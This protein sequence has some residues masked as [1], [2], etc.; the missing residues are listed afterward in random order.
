MTGTDVKQLQIFL[1]THNFTVSNTGPG[2]RGQET[3]YF[4]P[5][6]YRALVKFQEYYAKDILIPVGL[7]RGTGYFG[8][9]TMKKVNQ[10]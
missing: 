4:G 5:A 1:N 6:T 7:S 8:V 9:S 2:S 10:F 3:T